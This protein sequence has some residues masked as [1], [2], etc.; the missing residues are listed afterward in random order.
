VPVSDHFLVWLSCFRS[1]WVFSVP[2]PFMN[3]K[4][5]SNLHTQRHRHTFMWARFPESTLSTVS[6][7][8]ESRITSSR[9]VRFLE[10]RGWRSGFSSSWLVRAPISILVFVGS[11]FTRP[12]E[13][14]ARESGLS[15]LVLGRLCMVSGVSSSLW[16]G[17]WSWS[18]RY[19][20][21]SVKRGEQLDAAVKRA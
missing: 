17:M 19:P 13:L 18:W 1:A 9:N 2:L 6:E 14:E 20:M 12:S 16:G 3:G 5:V 11:S 15:T 10:S 8:S 21:C 4:W 7:L